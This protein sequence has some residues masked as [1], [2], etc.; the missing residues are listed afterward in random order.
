MIFLIDYLEVYLSS[1]QNQLQIS[2]GKHLNKLFQ[3]LV[4]LD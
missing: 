2:L 4:F 1:L 3:K